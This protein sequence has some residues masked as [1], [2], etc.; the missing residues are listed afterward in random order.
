MPLLSVEN[1]SM[2]SGPRRRWFKYGLSGEMLLDSVSFEIDPGKCL[3]LVGGEASGKLPVTFALLGLHSISDGKITFDGED[4]TRLSLRKFRPWRKR[5]QAVFPDEFG[6]LTPR[7]TLER[8]FRHVLKTWYPKAKK[9]EIHNR[10]EL[11]MD[12]VKMPTANRHRTP[13]ELDPAERQL[14]AVARAMLV[15]PDLLICH[16]VTKGLDVAEQAEVLNRISDIRDALNLT[17]M[18]VTDDLAVADHMSDT[19]AVLHH[20]RVLETGPAAKIVQHPDHDYTRRLVSSTL[21]NFPT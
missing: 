5:I 17:V 4:L 13:P 18:L 7:H 10:I 21:T 6:Q 12:L 8:S 14:M 19:I 15:E 9:E 11:A 2:E 16:E 20:G 1:L 3:G